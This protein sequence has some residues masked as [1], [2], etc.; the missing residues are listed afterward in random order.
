MLIFDLLTTYTYWLMYEL[1]NMYELINI[2]WIIPYMMSFDA[3]TLSEIIRD[4]HMCL[5]Y[6]PHKVK[7][8]FHRLQIA[9][10]CAKLLQYDQKEIN[11][12]KQFLSTQQ[13]MLKER[14]LKED[15]EYL[16]GTCILP[17]INSNFI[18]NRWYDVNE[19]VITLKDT[20]ESKITELFNEN[21]KIYMLGLY[22]CKQCQDICDNDIELQELLDHK[23]RIIFYL[24]GGSA[25]RL[26][27]IDHIRKS[28][29]SSCEKQKFLK[30]VNSVFSKGG[31]NDVGFKIIGKL[32]LN[33]KYRDI[34]TRYVANLIFHKVLLPFISSNMDK[35][36]HIV[37]KCLIGK[38]INTP[39]GSTWVLEYGKKVSKVIH[40]SPDRMKWKY[41]AVGKP[42][43]I[44][45][46][47]NEIKFSCNEKI[48]HFMLT[49]Y[50]I[51]LM[52]KLKKASDE[53]SKNYL[54][55]P[56][57]LKH[58]SEIGMKVS[59]EGFDVASDLCNDYRYMQKYNI[60]KID[61]NPEDI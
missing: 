50:K 59:G 37:D 57:I 15:K 47:L 25:Y 40:H 14:M 2:L 28:K 3:L 18:A 61:I 9:I 16:K 19:R 17:N 52:A 20:I 42:S 31:D 10:E 26:T 38:E 4:Q 22:L 7:K 39:D 35:I 8:R 30:K 46:T 43:F 44:Y 13:N 5:L 33:S 53:L 41:E 49:R 29:L 12:A 51:C 6:A 34:I 24:K 27:I 55:N 56:D 23:Y 1:T 54:D 48:S 58:F 60:D 21:G 36:K 11:E 32:N 45:A